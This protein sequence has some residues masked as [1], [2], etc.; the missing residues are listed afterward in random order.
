MSVWCGRGVQV[1]RPLD[2]WTDAIEVPDC[3]TLT[4]TEHGGV[5]SMSINGDG[6]TGALILDLASRER[7]IDVTGESPTAGAVRYRL[8]WIAWLRDVQDRAATPM[9]GPS[10]SYYP[11]GPWSPLQQLAVA[12]GGTWYPPPAVA[13]EGRRHRSVYL[14]RR[15]N[16]SIRLR[17]ARLQ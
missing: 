17:R 14:F 1:H 7:V 3:W 11:N 8:Q 12:A 13:A 5:L 2:A 9:A 16:R 15:V 6:S 4:M 10:P